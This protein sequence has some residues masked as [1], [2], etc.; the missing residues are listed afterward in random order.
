MAKLS[1]LALTSLDGYTVDAHGDFQWAAPDVEVSTF[2]NDLE[3]GV[4]TYLFGRRMYETMLF[5][6]GYQSGPDDADSTRDFAQIWN[7]AD[8]IVYSRTLETT[9][10]ERTRLE[11]EFD[12]SAVAR[13]KETATSDLS[14]GGA[15]LAGF[16]ME[17]GLVDEVH[18]FVVPQLVGGGTSTLGPD[19]RASLD[20]IGLD[21]FAAGVVHLH[22]RTL[23]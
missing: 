2:V 15:H 13:M 23:T 8:K 18:L 22:Y 16:A 9:A 5:W 7:G 1:Y 11:R 21:R 17:L 4:G 6:E 14:I 10:S 20:L 12:G 3:R 19:V